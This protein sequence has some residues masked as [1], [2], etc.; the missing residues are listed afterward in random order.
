M[1]LQDSTRYFV[2]ARTHLG[3][4]GHER[5]YDS[6]EAAIA[7]INEAGLGNMA[8]DELVLIAG[9]ELRLVVTIGKEGMT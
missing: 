5:G 7:S 2:V 8:S 4:N 3:E 9:Q 1:E 6:L